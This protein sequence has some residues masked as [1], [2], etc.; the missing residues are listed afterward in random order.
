M[1]DYR[2]FWKEFS[3]IKETA[4]KKILKKHNYNDTI[5]QLR[6]LSAEIEFISLFN[7]FFYF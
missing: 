6:Q 7:D 5:N 2:D 1:N 3:L 4:R